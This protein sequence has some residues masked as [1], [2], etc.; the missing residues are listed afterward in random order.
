MTPEE[1]QAIVSKGKKYTMV[2]LLAGPNRSLDEAAAKQLQLEHLSYLLSLRK[3]GKLLINGPVL[4]EGELLG[5][6]IYASADLDE[7]KAI[8][9]NDPAVKAGRI[10]IK[11]FPWFGIPGDQLI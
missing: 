5:V 11:A 8:A 7:V 9:E 6:S 10:I 2:H 4:A 1:I 3:E